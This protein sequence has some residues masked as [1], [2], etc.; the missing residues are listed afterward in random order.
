[1][2]WHIELFTALPMD[3]LHLFVYKASPFISNYFYWIMVLKFPAT[4]MIIMLSLLLLWPWRRRQCFIH[5]T[6][7]YLI[8][9]VSFDFVCACVCVERDTHKGTEIIKSDSHCVRIYNDN[10]KKMLG[11]T[12]PV[13]HV[14]FSSD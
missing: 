12:K 4:H 11:K 5:L 7:K 2:D 6:Y 10:R 9:I 8:I 14:K 3:F 1:M 13:P